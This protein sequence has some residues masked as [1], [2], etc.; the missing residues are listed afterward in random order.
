MN[1]HNQV[2]ATPQ[3]IVTCL[4]NNM[5]NNPNLLHS[6]TIWKK[7]PMLSLMRTQEGN[8]DIFNRIKNPNINIWKQSIANKLSRLAL[9][10]GVRVKVLDT[11]LSVVKY[12]VSRDR[13]QYVTYGDIVE[14]YQP[15]KEVPHRT[16]LTVGGN[17][18]CYSEDISTPPSE[19][20]TASS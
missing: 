12:Q 16:R 15:K 13:I 20:T 7:L 14:E 10:A 6:M 19:I 4:Q 8:S 3:L 17:I 2:K 18:I 1:G 11:M 5:R 9:G